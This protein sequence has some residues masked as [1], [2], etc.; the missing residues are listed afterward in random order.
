[1]LRWLE[2]E[3]FLFMGYRRYAVRREGDEWRVSLEPS[4]AL[5][6]LCDV[7]DSR[8]TELDASAPVPALVASRLD[9]E[10]VIF[11]D[12]TRS[13]STVHRRGRLDSVSVKL[14]DER[15]RVIGF[16]RFVGLLTNR[17]MRM[18]PSA[19]AVLAA[20][21]ARVVEALGPSRAR[22]RTSSRSRPRLPAA[23]IPVAGATQ[24]G[25][26]GRREHRRGSGARR[27]QG[28]ERVRSR[29]SFL[30]RLGG[31]AAPDP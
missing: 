26:A 13:D 29:E 16:G 18:R 23:R 5:G 11:F 3:G 2:S 31:P 28:R 30:L 19:L 22:T 24:R 12:K 27:D 4:S 9:D 10:R 1:M 21:R 7:E 20:R 15:A 25:D 8:F 6:I 14:L 17:A